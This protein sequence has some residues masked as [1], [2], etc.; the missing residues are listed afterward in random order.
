MSLDSTQ[1]PQGGELLAAISQRIVQMLREY[2]GKG[3]TRAASYWAGSDILLVILGGGY[4]TG[5]ETLFE[6]GH[7]R[8]VRE[9]REALQ[10]TLAGRMC[11][12]VEELTG[13]DVVAV[14]GGSHQKPDLSTEVFVFESAGVLTDDDQMS[15]DG[16]N[17]PHSDDDC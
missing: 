5:E 9:Y 2:A 13:R 7:E 10:D 15:A 16:E 1:R 11:E 4:T 14:V 8:K 12:V 3:P 17:Q 6:G